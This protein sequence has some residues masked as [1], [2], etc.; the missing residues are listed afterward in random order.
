MAT[1]AID[2]DTDLFARPPNALGVQTSD[3]KRYT[4]DDKV[5]VD[6]CSKTPMSITVDHSGHSIA[7]AALC[8]PGVHKVAEEI[9]LGL[10]NERV[11]VRFTIGLRL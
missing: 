1:M 5:L 4:L 2:D 10:E 3:G 8:L 9:V 6:L 11:E 7:G